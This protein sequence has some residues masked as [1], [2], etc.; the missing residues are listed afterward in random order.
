MEVAPQPERWADPKDPSKAVVRAVREFES[1]GEVSTRVRQAWSGHPAAPTLAVADRNSI[2]STSRPET[3]HARTGFVITH[4]A[5]GAA[6]QAASIGL[7][8]K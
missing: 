6:M 7:N 3:R 4:G 1:Q 2:S 8:W 5:E